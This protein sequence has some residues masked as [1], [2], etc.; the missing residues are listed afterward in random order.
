MVLLIGEKAGG[1]EGGRPRGRDGAHALRRSN[2]A[3]CWTFFRELFR[4]RNSTC[5]QN[6]GKP[7]GK[8]GEHVDIA[9]GV[10][11]QL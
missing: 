11:E 6:S 9:I 10:V 3:S 2:G 7:G 5:G 1:G 8:P 4:G